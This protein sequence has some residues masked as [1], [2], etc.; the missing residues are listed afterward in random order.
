[1]TP[2]LNEWQ[3]RLAYQLKAFGIERMLWLGPSHQNFEQ[4]Y[5]EQSFAAIWP[6]SLPE[7]PELLSSYL[8]WTASKSRTIRRSF[9]VF[10]EVDSIIRCGHLVAQAQDAGIELFIVAFWHPH[11]TVS[12]DFYKEWC[13]GTNVRF[14]ATQETDDS[15]SFSQL[16][17]ACWSK[18]GCKLLLLPVGERARGLT[19]MLSSIKATLDPFYES[20]QMGSLVIRQLN[21]VIADSDEVLVLWTLDFAPPVSWGGLH[22]RTVRADLMHV[23]W[24]LLGVWMA[25]KVPVLVVHEADLR[26]LSSLFART[27]FM[28]RPVLVLFVT[29]R[30]KP[31][32]SSVVLAD[33]LA[34][35]R[36]WFVACPGDEQ[37][38]ESIIQW[39]LSAEVSAFVALSDIRIAGKFRL[40]KGPLSRRSRVL[41]EGSDLT[42]WVF[43][44]GIYHA[45]LAAEYMTSYKVDCEVID[46]RWIFPLDREQLAASAKTRGIVVIEDEHLMMGSFQEIEQWLQDHGM[47]CPVFHESL[48]LEDDEGAWNYAVEPLVARLKSLWEELKP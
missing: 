23:Y 12:L 1:M 5:Q 33:R 47:K 24:W 35:G 22:Y 6:E 25:D 44:P 38:T 14:Y 32:A 30:K 9:V 13:K 45:I 36:R 28:D 2:S 10:E 11:D 18:S 41:R 42:L 19:D 16:L 8:A 39:S 15:Q 4:Q 20:D 31:F 17:N 27:D 3:E 7:D 26:V 48:V 34:F 46:A 29:D 21:R 37:D 40:P 43:G